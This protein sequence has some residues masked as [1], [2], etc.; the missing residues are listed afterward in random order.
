M[1]VIR[2]P[3]FSLG[4]CNVFYSFSVLLFHCFLFAVGAAAQA[5]THP[6][7]K[8]IAPPS[9]EVESFF[10][11]PVVPLLKHTRLDALVTQQRGTSDMGPVLPQP[12]SQTCSMGKYPVAGAV[13]SSV[14][15]LVG[16]GWGGG[17]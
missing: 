6:I 5:V 10:Y 4:S 1:E 12:T 8:H 15:L 13:K 17:Q 7:Q 11:V 2:N 3:L 14:C 9:S 16:F